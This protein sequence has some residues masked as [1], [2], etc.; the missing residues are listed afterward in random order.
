M[1]RSLAVIRARVEGL[2]RDLAPSEGCA[3]C[4]ADQGLPRIV[5]IINGAVGSRSPGPMACST[6]GLSYTVR[7]V[8]H[9]HLTAA[10]AAFE[11]AGA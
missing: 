10:P 9:G 3:T 1:A 5:H 11:P 6:C 8:V 4:R 7:R 2:A